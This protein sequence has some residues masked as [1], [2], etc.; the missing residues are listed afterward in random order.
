MNGSQQWTKAGSTLKSV[1]DNTTLVLVVPFQARWRSELPVEERK[2]N[3]NV[4]HQ[5]NMV[6]NPA[7]S[8]A[9][10]AVQFALLLQPPGKGW[11]CVGF[12]TLS[13]ISLFVCERVCVF[14]LLIRGYIDYTP[15]KL[16]D[17]FSKGWKLA[18]TRLKMWQLLRWVGVMII[19]FSLTNAIKKGRRYV[20]LGLIRF[21]QSQKKK[22][23]NQTT[24]QLYRVKNFTMIPHRWG[25]EDF[26]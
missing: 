4:E 18:R 8:K 20:K 5:M 14:E 21:W 25:K 19:I 7:P 16:W 11:R 1:A 22:N 13:F 2:I 26:E 10:R 15:Q 17:L 9:S 3:I 12:V 6:F 24:F 23:R